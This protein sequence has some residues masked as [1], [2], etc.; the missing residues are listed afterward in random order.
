MELVNPFFLD[1]IDFCLLSHYELSSSGRLKSAY[2]SGLLEHTSVTL[3]FTINAQPGHITRSFS[4][5]KVAFLTGMA[6]LRNMRLTI[7]EF[8]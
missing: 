7:L 5:P 8:S 2:F 4:N 6:I 1:F 3:E